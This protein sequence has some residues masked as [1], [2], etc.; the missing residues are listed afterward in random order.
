MVA[1]SRDAAGIMLRVVVR[2]GEGGADS[3]AA[4]RCQACCDCRIRDV[5]FCGRTTIGRISQ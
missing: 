5:P 3:N 1:A 4:G 2:S